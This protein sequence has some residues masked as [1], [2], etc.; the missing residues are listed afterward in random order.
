MKKRVF[1]DLGVFVGLFVC[2]VIF[3]HFILKSESPR[4]SKDISNKEFPTLYYT[5]IGDSL[6]EGVGDSTGQGGFIPIVS[7]LLSQDYDVVVK[8][9]NFGVSG[10]TSEQILS[11]IQKKEEIQKGIE[12][13]DFLTITVGGNDI[14]KVIKE[15]FAN[16]SKKSF[17][18]PEVAYQARIQRIISEIRERNKTAPIY[19]V[20]VYNPYY[21]N[22]SEI[23]EMQEIIDDWNDGT[24]KVVTA[25]ENCFFVPVNDL[26]SQ[27]LNGGVEEKNGEATTVVND[28]LFTEDQFHPNDTGY[29]LMAKAVLEEMEGTKK[30]WLKK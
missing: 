16:L 12:K 18:K 14:M 25:Q 5:A 19:V 2:V 3:T 8:S 10:N 9:E 15:N 26:I 11:R 27:G 22:F 17:T 29:Q 20:G 30:L 13:A 6:T 28:A 24:K 7:N 23:K 1:I 4:M 21:L